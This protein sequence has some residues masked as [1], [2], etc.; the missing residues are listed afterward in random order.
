MWP[1][2]L[3][4]PPM[5]PQKSLVC[6]LTS[7]WIMLFCQRDYLVVTSKLSH[8]LAPRHQNLRT[9]THTD[10]EPRFNERAALSARARKNMSKP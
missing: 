2:L 5:C 7:F 1:G 9:E 4:F 10:T 8:V 3:V 6:V